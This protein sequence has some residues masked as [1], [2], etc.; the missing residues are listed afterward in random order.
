M[1]GFHESVTLHL[2]ET[3]PLLRQAQQAAL[4]AFEPMWH[5]RVA[6]L[7]PGPLLLVANEFFDALPVHVYQRTPE[8]WRERLVALD[9]AGAGFQFVLSA[10]LPALP[11]PG[12]L[13]AAAGSVVEVAPAYDVSEIT[14][15]AAA[16]IAH[17]ILCLLVLKKGAV[18]RVVGRV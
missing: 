16:T 6:D 9:P 5:A 13:E 12:G 10:A 11:L 15:L 4:G 1:P 2:V 7:P 14:A 8:G 17:D 3:N 18:E